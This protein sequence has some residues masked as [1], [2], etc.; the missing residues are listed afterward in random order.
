MLGGA[1]R[2][3]V[4]FSAAYEPHLHYPIF[5]E[6]NLIIKRKQVARLGA[7][8]GQPLSVA[9][10]VAAAEQHILQLAA[11]RTA[12]CLLPHSGRGSC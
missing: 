3:L 11:N 5:R 8:V 10:R 2:A 4:S 7:G 12:G 6:V 1:L 9:P